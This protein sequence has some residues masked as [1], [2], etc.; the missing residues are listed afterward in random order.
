MPA[1]YYKLSYLIIL[2]EKEKKTLEL[3]FSLLSDLEM[4]FFFYSSCFFTLSILEEKNLKISAKGF[5][6]FLISR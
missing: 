1:F 3:Q 5:S 2:F 4:I 6:S